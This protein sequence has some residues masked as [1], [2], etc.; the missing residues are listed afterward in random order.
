MD[1]IF[2]IFILVFSV[3]IHEV[4]HGYA[5]DSLGDPTARLEGRLTMNPLKHIDP[6]GSIILPLLL[7]ISG[8]GFL[9]GWAK[10]V[11][12]NVYNLRN[13]RWGEAI[14]AFA[15]PLS[16]IVIAIVFGGLIR[17]GISTG[18]IENANILKITS[19]IVLINIVLATFNLIPIPP[20]DGSKIF[21]SIF[22]IGWNKGRVFLERYGIFIVLFFVFFF[23]GAVSPIIAKFFVLLTGLYI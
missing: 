9:I 19:Y 3:I 13:Q 5:A 4:A 8:S 14:V 16:N 7:F 22:N 15:G 20:L 21:F 12:Y 23:W 10:P 17:F 11:P 2:E 6:F 18:F 1:F